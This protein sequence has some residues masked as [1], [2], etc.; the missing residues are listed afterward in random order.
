MFEWSF[1]LYEV[2]CKLTEKWKTKIPK[3]IQAEEYIFYRYA[4]NW[5]VNNFQDSVNKKIFEVV[6]Y[7][8]K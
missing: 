4:I 6:S 5:I 2:R 1:P 8:K 7:K 3:E